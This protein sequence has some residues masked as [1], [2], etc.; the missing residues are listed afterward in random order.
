MALFWSTETFFRCHLFWSEGLTVYESFERFDPA[1]CFVIQ[2]HFWDVQTLQMNPMLHCI[3][4]CFLFR[5]IH[6]TV[7][8]KNYWRGYEGAIAIR[9]EGHWKAHRREGHWKAHTLHQTCLIIWSKMPTLSMYTDL[10]KCDV[11]YKC[12][13]VYMKFSALLYVCFQI[14]LPE[15]G[16]RLDAC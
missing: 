5:W 11:L 8:M 9:R 16:T 10:L 3:L 6:D 13:C 4:F 1:K 14:N 2:I 15:S 12:V 7:W